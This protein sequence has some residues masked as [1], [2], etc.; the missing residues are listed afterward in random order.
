LN[1]NIANQI[2]RSQDELANALHKQS[3]S[4]RQEAEKALK[5][6][7]LNIAKECIEIAFEL[8]QKSVASIR[9]K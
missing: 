7:H 5:D 9:K 6:G 3:Q 4:L 2:E 8:I 1:K